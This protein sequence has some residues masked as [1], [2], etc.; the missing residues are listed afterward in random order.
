TNSFFKQFKEEERLKME[1]WA[2]AQSEFLQSS[3]TVDLGSL[4][5]KVFQNNT[6]TPMILI[7]KDKSIRVNNFPPNKAQDSAYIQSQLKKFK[8]ENTPISIDQQGEH[9]ATLYY[10]NSDVLTKLKFYPIALLL[11]IFLFAAVIYFLFKT[12][13]AAEQN[14]LWAGM[15]KET[16]HQ[17]G[18]PLSSL[19]GWNE[20]LKSEDINPSITKEIEKDIDR[21][22]T[23]TERFSKIGSLPKLVES[24]IVKET[25]DAFDYLKRRSSKLI[26]FS[27]SSKVDHLPVMLNSSLYNWTIEN[28]VKNGIDAMRGKGSIAIEIVPDH[29]FVNILI[30]DTGHGI[31]K[32]NYNSIFTPG[33]TSKKRGWGL[34]LSLVKRIVEEYHDGK[35]KVL[36]SGKEG[37][38]MQISLKVVH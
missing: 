22:Q 20:L 16:A 23:I 29:K 31:S 17:I 10:G 18:T 14:K 33:F 34:G 13:K 2:T 5:L 15:A 11:I 6:S 35:I 8:N 4:H 24:D 37:T 3:E 36:S 27:F 38:I 32:S 12:N 30:A 19:L 21:L 7:N 25:Q 28:L 9:L 1:I 26:H